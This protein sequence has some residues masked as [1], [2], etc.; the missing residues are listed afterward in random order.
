[1][2]HDVPVN[3]ETAWAHYRVSPS[4]RA[5]PSAARGNDAS[6]VRDLKALRDA[7]RFI[8]TIEL[9]ASAFGIP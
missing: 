4:V 7:V 1:V 3:M 8:R 2:R 9:S 5:V 6:A